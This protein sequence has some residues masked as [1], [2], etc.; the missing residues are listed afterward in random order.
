LALPPRA[1]A[2]ALTGTCATAQPPG[3]AS[4]ACPPLHG[5]RV[6]VKARECNTPGAEAV[7][8][9][10]CFATAPVHDH[11]GAPCRLACAVATADGL[12]PAP[13]PL[14]PQPGC[15]GPIGARRTPARR[16]RYG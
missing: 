14:P 5:L 6:A 13:V 2:S 12:D 15:A 9:A 4:R 10:L 7:A 1:P 8:H 11:T 3:A 16:W